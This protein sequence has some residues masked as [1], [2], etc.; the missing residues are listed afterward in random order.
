MSVFKIPVKEFKRSNDPLDREEKRKYTCY[1]HVDNVPKNIPMLT[2]P[3]EQKLTSSVAKKIE[4]SLLSNDGNF[5]MKNRGI[6]ISADK[7]IFDNKTDTM[8]MVVTEPYEHGDIDGGH[9]Y[10]LILEHQ[11]EGVIQYVS[12]EIMVGVEDIIED[13]AEARN[14]SS[15]VDEKSMAELGKH[16][17][18]I[19]DGIGGMPFFNRIAFKQNQQLVVDDKNVKMIDAREIVAILTMFHVKRYGAENHPM[20]AYSSKARVLKDYLQN[21]SDFEKFTDIATDIFDL[22]DLIELDFAEAYNKTGGRY[23]AKKYSGYKTGKNDEPL[24][25]G[26]SKFSLE[27]MQY[28]VPDGLIYPLLTA[29]RS[30]VDYDEKTDKYLWRKRPEVVYNE[31]RESI[32]SKVVKFTESIGNN[33]NATGKDS[34]VWDMLYMTVKLK[35]I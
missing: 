6:V 3:R 9:T 21:P 14:T 5:H 2:N 32:V 23:G 7:V 16:F 27:P 8:T 31:I 11:N 13:L 25:V 29:F 30:L 4:E 28:K 1:V 24:V 20:H 33:P 35:A 10:K 34:N 15:Q 18:P 22:Y 19:K 26:K 12:F 17:E